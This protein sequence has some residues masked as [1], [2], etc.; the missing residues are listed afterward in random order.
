MLCTSE[1]TQELRKRKKKTTTLTLEI[2]KFIKTT[3]SKP[4]TVWRV[5][6]TRD[7]HVATTCDFLQDQIARCCVTATACFMAPQQ[8]LANGQKTMVLTH[9]QKKTPP[10]LSGVGL[11]SDKVSVFI[12]SPTDTSMGMC[13]CTLR[14]ADG[15]MAPAHAH[16][17]SA[18]WRICTCASF[19]MATS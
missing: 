16:Y 15:Q 1:P 2:P 12:H 3:S 7:M 19:P 13:L 11:S 17:N 18:P 4:I 9:L 10:I 8:S 6:G 5:C 14:E